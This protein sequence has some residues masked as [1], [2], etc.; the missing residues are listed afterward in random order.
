MPL[1]K[2]GRNPYTVGK[3][4]GMKQIVSSSEEAESSKQIH[5]LAFW[6]RTICIVCRD[7]FWVA[8][9]GASCGCFSFLEA[10]R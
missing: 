8:P 6:T 3:R 9:M 4:N 10:P 2:A 5:R 7:E 1:T